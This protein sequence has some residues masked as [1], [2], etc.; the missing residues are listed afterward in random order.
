MIVWIF[1]PWCVHERSSASVSSANVR[2]CVC[3]IVFSIT[4]SNESEEIAKISGENGHPWRMPRGC[5]SLVC[6]AVEFNVEVV[7]AV[8]VVHDLC[9]FFWCTEGR[10]SL[11][12]EVPGNRWEGGGKVVED[13]CGVFVCERVHVG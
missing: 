9:C 7:V 2:R 4:L 3:G 6:A 12:C 8:E 10:E 13:K 5:E 1:F 11:K